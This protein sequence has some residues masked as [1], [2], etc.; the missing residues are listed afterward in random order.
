M[1]YSRPPSQEVLVGESKD[2]TENAFVGGRNRWA[3]STF[4]N[5]EMWWPNLPI[6]VYFK[7]RRNGVI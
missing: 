5:W 2:A 7:V 1:N 4:T 6:L 3:Y